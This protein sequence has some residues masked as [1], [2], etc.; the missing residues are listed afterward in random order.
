M[1][2]GHAWTCALLAHLIT[3]TARVARIL[4][5]PKCLSGMNLNCLCAAHDLLLNRTYGAKSIHN[6]V[7]DLMTDLS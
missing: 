3:S 5:T 7:Q 6:E 2:G 4:E 1:A